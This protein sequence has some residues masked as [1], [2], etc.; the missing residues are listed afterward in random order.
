MAGVFICP[1]CGAATQVAPEF[2]GRSGPCAHCG[3]PIVIPAELGE[4]AAGATRPRGNRTV[5]VLT[6]IAVLA[7]IM[8][9]G[10]V[11]GGR[12]LVGMMQAWIEKQECSERMRR[13]GVSL[14]AYYDEYSAYPPVVV[15]DAGG[16]P[17]HSWRV[18]LLPHLGKEEEALY[19]DYRFDEPWDGPHNRELAELMPAAYGCQCDPAAFELS[20]TSYLAVVDATS[21]DFAAPPQIAEANQ[22]PQTKPAAAPKTKYLVVEMCESGVNWLEPR[23]LVLGSPPPRRSVSGRFSYH[24]GGVNALVDDGTMETLSEEQAEAAFGKPAKISP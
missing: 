12:I 13:L 11:V 5:I 22:P 8:L 4:G 6:T 17:M 21:G 7:G 19:K 3:R 18:L 23:D 2:V 24:V 1:Y 15:R 16:A 20:Q 10:L 14:N 9:V